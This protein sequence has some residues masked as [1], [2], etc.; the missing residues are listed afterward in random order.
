M[1]CK[2]TLHLRRYVWDI[3]SLSILLLIVSSTIV[4]TVVTPGITFQTAADMLLKIFVPPILTIIFHE[5]LHVITAIKLG[6]RVKVGY[7]RIRF[8]PVFYVKVVGGIRR[9]HYIAIVLSP[10]IILSLISMVFALIVSNVLVKEILSVLLIMNTAGSSGDILLALSVRKMPQ[11]ALIEDYG[12]MIASD[13]PIPCPY[14][15]KVSLIIKI[16]TLL[17]IVA[18]IIL[19]KVEVVVVK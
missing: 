9:K 8:N 14:S 16:L 13:K 3:T 17:T 1:N 12:T 10:L 2:Y 5:L 7:G 18:I 19:L 11:E 15:K 4:F 6:Y